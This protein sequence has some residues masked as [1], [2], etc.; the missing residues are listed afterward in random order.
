MT[1]KNVFITLLKSVGFLPTFSSNQLTHNFK[2]T[3]DLV[4]TYG[5]AVVENY[6]LALKDTLVTY[7]KVLYKARTAYYSSL[8]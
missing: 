3:L 5:V 4:L 1:W 2:N 7:K 8:E 6:H